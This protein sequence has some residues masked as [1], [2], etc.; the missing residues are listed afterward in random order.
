[1]EDNPQTLYIPMGVKSETEL[2]PGFGR[3]Q[4]FQS[5]IGSL[6]AG[7]VALLLWIFGRSVSLTMVTFLIGVSAS[8]MMTTKDRMNLSV[9]DQMKQMIR[10]AKG[11]KK[12]PYI[13]MNEWPDKP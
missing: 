6:G 10:F 5:V 12:Y 9:L 2:F 13:A 8:V 4:L 7:F 3:K 11:Q 1:M